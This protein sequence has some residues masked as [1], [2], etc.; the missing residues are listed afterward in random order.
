DPRCDVLGKPRRADRFQLRRA[1][2]SRSTERSLPLDEPRGRRN[3]GRAFRSRDR[4]RPFAPVLCRL[5]EI[6]GTGLDG[7]F[8][9]VQI[10]LETQPAPQGVHA[11]VEHIALDR[12][13]RLHS[14]SDFEYLADVTRYSVE[15]PFGAG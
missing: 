14:G 8:A 12:A 4:R 2:I 10:G 7:D 11:R 6:A 13:L 5:I 15:A 3:D 1:A 9:A